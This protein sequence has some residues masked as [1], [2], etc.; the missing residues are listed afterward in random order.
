MSQASNQ[1]SVRIGIARQGAVQQERPTLV[2]L[3]IAAPDAPALTELYPAFKVQKRRSQG[4]TV[5]LDQIRLPRGADL[6]K[7]PGLRPGAPSMIRDAVELAMISGAKHVDVALAFAPDLMPWNV[8][9][10]VVFPLLRQVLEESPGSLV[11]MPD[12]AGPAQVGLRPPD[13]KV[14]LGGL[15]QTVRIFASTL[16][17]HYQ[18]ALLDLPVVPADMLYSALPNAVRSDVALCAWTGRGDALRRH[19]WRSAAAVVAG[20]ILAASKQPTASLVGRSFELP[21]GRPPADDRI[22]MLGV[23][24]AERG[25]PEYVADALLE[26]ALDDAGTSCTIKSENTARTPVGSWTVPMLRTAKLVHERIALTA[27]LMT[28]RSA[29]PDQAFLLQAGLQTALEGYFRMG[30]LTGQDPT[31]PPEVSAEPDPRPDRPSLIANVTAFLR[32]WV[33]RVN[34]NV[35]VRPGGAAGAEA[36]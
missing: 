29:T 14:Q 17:T 15:V 24:P 31:E 30:V 13:P 23:P 6:S 16:S 21:G 8:G 1:V 19:G 18:V 2:V 11:L 10:R 3:G 36:S 25:L 33:R 34:I 9:S 35:A 7:L 32:P 4:G 5:G 28:F 12:V 26:V 20:G 27:D 22:R